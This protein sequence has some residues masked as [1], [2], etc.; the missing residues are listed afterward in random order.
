MTRVGFEPTTYGL[1]VMTDL[2]S[3]FYLHRLRSLFRRGIRKL[4]R[5][6]ASEFDA[7]YVR[8]AH[9]SAHV[10][11]HA[12]PALSFASTQGAAI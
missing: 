3:G 8:L 9:N 12:R 2:S 10:V 7:V 6:C 5:P 4:E 1:K 11:K